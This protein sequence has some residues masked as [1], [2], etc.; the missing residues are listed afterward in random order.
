MDIQKLLTG[1]FLCVPDFICFL[2]ILK[3]ILKCQNICPSL[4]YKWRWL[5][6][7]FTTM[8]PH[9]A[10]TFAPLVS[11]IQKQRLHLF[12]TSPPVSVRHVP[13]CAQWKFSPAKT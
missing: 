3:L 9:S 4:P 6:M 12:V 2:K 13:A 10:I 11:F 8:Q 7:V 5:V 1:F